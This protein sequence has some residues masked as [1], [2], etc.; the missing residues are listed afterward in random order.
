MKPSKQQQQQQ[1][2]FFGYNND[3]NSKLLVLAAV[4]RKWPS[5]SAKAN[6]IAVFLPK[7]SDFFRDKK[8]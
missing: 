1:Q 5:P 2:L 6:L 8:T 7:F 4:I 3:N